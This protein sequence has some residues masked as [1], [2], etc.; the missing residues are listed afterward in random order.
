[1]HVTSYNCYHVH[2]KLADQPIPFITRVTAEHMDP[3]PIVSVGK[4]LYGID[5]LYNY[6]CIIS[7]YIPN[8]K[9]MLP[10]TS[11]LSEYCPWRRVF[12]SFSFASFHS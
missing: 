3:Y 7:D 8:I 12:Q 11:V 9:P 10:A 2:L 6:R 4:G 5:K 1:M